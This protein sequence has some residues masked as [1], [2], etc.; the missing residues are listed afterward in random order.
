MYKLWFGSLFECNWCRSKKSK[1]KSKSSKSDEARNSVK[2]SWPRWPEGFKAHESSKQARKETQVQEVPSNA[3]PNIDTTLPTFIDYDD[4]KDQDLSNSSVKVFSET[5]S[6]QMFPD[7]EDS[8]PFESIVT[9]SI[10]DGTVEPEIS[11]DSCE[12]VFPEQNYFDPLDIDSMM[13]STIEESLFASYDSQMD[14]A[15]E[16]FS[17]LGH[18]FTAETSSEELQFQLEV[19]TDAQE[20]T[21]HKVLGSMDDEPFIRYF[22]IIEFLFFNLN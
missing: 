1:N 6:L 13:E 15:Q 12:Q 22:Y 20:E 5:S 21:T 4:Y 7:E 16:V 2:I 9:T 11:H 8:Q 10:I 14:L 18:M 17:E 3:A 19:V